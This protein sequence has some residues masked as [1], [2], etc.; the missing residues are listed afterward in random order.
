MLK[1]QI[2]RCCKSQIIRGKI[3]LRASMPKGKLRNDNELIKTVKWYLPC[4][5]ACSHSQLRFCGRMAPKMPILYL[6]IFLN[7]KY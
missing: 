6:S 2:C 1:I 4:R 5:A 3:S 7:F